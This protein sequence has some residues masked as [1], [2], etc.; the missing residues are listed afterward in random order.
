VSDKELYDLYV[1]HIWAQVPGHYQDEIESCEEVI[2]KGIKAILE[3]DRARV[4][5]KAGEPI[6]CGVSTEGAAWAAESGRP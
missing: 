6:L 5:R 1:E 3:V 2:L 4:F